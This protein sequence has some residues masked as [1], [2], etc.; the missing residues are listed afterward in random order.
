MP[1]ICRYMNSILT[2]ALRQGNCADVRDRDSNADCQDGDCC[3]DHAM[4]CFHF[5][6]GFGF[7]VP[8]APPFSDV[9]GA[10]IWYNPGM[11]LNP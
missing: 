3:F 5:R 11:W 7:M 8:S 6:L 9:V 4:S 1:G 2:Q 10:A